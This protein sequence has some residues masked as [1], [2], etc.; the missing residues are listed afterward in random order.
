MQI[1]CLTNG[2]KNAL[3]RKFK[4]IV[5]GLIAKGYVRRIGGCVDLVGTFNGKYRRLAWEKPSCTVDT[6][7]GE[8]GTFCILPSCGAL[9]FAKQLAYKHSLIVC[10]PRQRNKT[11]YRLIGNAVPPPLASYA[12]EITLQLLGRA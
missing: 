8:Q 5:E 12:A 7:F 2:C 3:G 11:Q 1:Q 9:L 6:R 10:F 4:R